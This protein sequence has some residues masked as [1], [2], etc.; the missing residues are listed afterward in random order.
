MEELKALLPGRVLTREAE[1]AP[2]ESD[3]LTALS[4][5]HI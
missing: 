2:Y 4:L 3:A 5:I 1:L